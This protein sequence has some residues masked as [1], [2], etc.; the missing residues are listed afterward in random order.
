MKIK[1]DQIDEGLYCAELRRSKAVSMESGMVVHFNVQTF[2]KSQEVAREK[3][4]FAL[5]ELGFMIDEEIRKFE[6]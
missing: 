3:V 5:A 6:A 1:I 4:L 2:G